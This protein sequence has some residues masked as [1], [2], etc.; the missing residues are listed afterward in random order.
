MNDMS[1][2]EKCTIC[3]GEFDLNTEG[4]ILGYLG[5]LPVSFCPTCEAGVYD[6]YEQHKEVDEQRE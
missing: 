2:E 6:M 3:G 1:P 4:G 5:I